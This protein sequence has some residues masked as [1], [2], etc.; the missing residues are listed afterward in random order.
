MADQEVCYQKTYS[1]ILKT[2]GLIRQSIDNG[3]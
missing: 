3:S 2:D 1:G